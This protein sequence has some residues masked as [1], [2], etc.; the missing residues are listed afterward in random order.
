M[1]PRLALYGSGM[2]AGDPRAFMS[3][4]GLQSMAG[5][6]TGRAMLLRSAYGDPFLGF[7][8]KGIGGLAKKVIGV[9]KKKPGTPTVGIG[10]PYYGPTGGFLTPAQQQVAQQAMAQQQ[11]VALPGGGT[12]VG[13]L[14]GKALGGALS[15]LDPS[16]IVRKAM[17]PPLQALGM[18]LAPGAGAA[19][20]RRRRRMN[21]LNPRALRRA[22]TRAH[23][24]E[25]FARQVVRIT[26]RFKR[27]TKRGL[28]G[29][30]RRAA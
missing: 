21:P 22:I 24:F 28:F 5:D 26:P 6:P 25:V 9:F 13:G 8:A 4:Q 15:V 17:G 23:R 7:L 2:L 19:G 29:R 10:A 27:R 20:G 16:G 3:R 11:L 30:R 1:T 12:T 14:A 18:K